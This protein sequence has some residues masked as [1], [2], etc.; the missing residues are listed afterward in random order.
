M[1]EAAIV[2][3]VFLVLLIVKGLLEAWL[4]SR[5]KANIR[6]NQN[7]VPARFADTISLSDHQKAADYT[8]AKINTSQFFHIID[9]FVL[10]IWTIGGGLNSLS[11]VVELTGVQSELWQGTLF[12]GLFILINGMIGL[13]RSI[14]STFVLEERFGFN[15]TTPKTFVL[16]LIKGT[17]VGV[18]I[19]LP[20]ILGVLWIMQALGQSWWFWAWVF[21]TAFQLILVWAYPT[22][23]APLF[24]KFSPMEE[25]ETKNRVEALLERTGFHS[26]GLFVMNAS[27]RSAHGNAYFTGFGKNKRIVFFDTL[28]KTLEPAEVEAVLAHELGHF[29]KKH[30]VKGMVKALGLSLIGFWVLG[31]LSTWQPFFD[32]LNAGVATN[33]KALLL[34]MLVAGVFTFPLTPLSAWMSRKYEFEADDFAAKNAQAKD[35]ITALVKLYKDNANTLTPDPIYSAWYHSHPPALTRVSHLE[36]LGS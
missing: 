27:M 24:N 25:G 35:L 4:D 7:L 11:S 6:R 32:G 36:S 31:Q 13:P 5:Q 18:V 3:K 33:A 1:H 20:I 14:Y 22:F 16:D 34:F 30:I 19:G 12:I 26:K 23:I 28:L 2:T 21:M 15:K 8:V 10:L 17:L 29:K 9:V